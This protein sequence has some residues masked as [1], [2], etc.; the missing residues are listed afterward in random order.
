MTSTISE[1][2]SVTPTNQDIQTNTNVNVI[3]IAAC[4]TVVQVVIPQTSTHS[5][6]IPKS[7]TQ[8]ISSSSPS[9]MEMEQDMSVEHEDMVVEDNYELGFSDVLFI[10]FNWVLFRVLKTADRYQVIAEHLSNGTIAGI[11]LKGTVKASSDEEI[12]AEKELKEHIIIRIKNRQIFL[13]LLEGGIRDAGNALLPEFSS[14]LANAIRV[15]LNTSIDDDQPWPRKPSV[16]KLEEWLF[17][18]IRQMNQKYSTIYVPISPPFDELIDLDTLRTNL[19]IERASPDAPPRGDEA[20]IYEI[21]ETDEIDE[22]NSTHDMEIIDENVNEERDNDNNN[23]N[24]S[25]NNNNTQSP[26]DGELSDNAVQVVEE[27]VSPVN[28]PKPDMDRCIKDILLHAFRLEITEVY[29]LAPAKE[30]NNML[31]HDIRGGSLVDRTRLRVIEQFKDLLAF[32]HITANGE[33]TTELNAQAKSE[34]DKISEEPVRLLSLLKRVIDTFKWSTEQMNAIEAINKMIK[35]LDPHQHRAPSLPPPAAASSPPPPS[36]PTNVSTTSYE[37]TPPKPIVLPNKPPIIKR[38]HYPKIR[39]N[40]SSHEVAEIVAAVK[41]ENV[42]MS[43]YLRRSHIDASVKSIFDDLA[44]GE[45][46]YRIFNNIG[47]TLKRLL[48]EQNIVFETNELNNVFKIIEDLCSS[49]T[50]VYHMIEGVLKNLKK[51][52]GCI[53]PYAETIEAYWYKVRNDY[54]S[55]S[56]SNLSKR[57]HPQSSSSVSVSATSHESSNLKSQESSNSVYMPSNTTSKHVAASHHESFRHTTSRAAQH[58]TRLPP[59]PHPHPQQQQQHYNEHRH[60]PQSNINGVESHV[61]LSSDTASTQSVS[62]D[63]S[64]ALGQ[65]LNQTEIT[66]LTLMLDRLPPHLRRRMLNRWI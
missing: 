48:E 7:V 13:Q 42:M 36:V 40:A 1:S 28:L 32:A 37:K 30:L 56:S 22:N 61:M 23:S 45:L 18:E 62:V 31:A 4:N 46:G 58:A 55:S 20:I 50:T 25:N 51:N 65:F 14:R 24:S 10:T 43:Q 19:I 66:H 33:F 38:H 16:G 27:S 59:Q 21:D 35:Q 6:I 41:L 49:R 63:Y 12:D 5:D 8:L 26:E 52:P 57:Q 47:S 60:P 39:Q 2:L 34:L 15:A 54:R 9:R 11:A 53:T 29:A 64:A 17:P 3:T 44:K